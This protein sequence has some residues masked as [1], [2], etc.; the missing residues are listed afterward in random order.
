VATSREHVAEGALHVLEA[1]AFE[2]WDG[3]VRLEEKPVGFHLCRSFLAKG[4]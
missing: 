4:W 1:E 2:L 3:S